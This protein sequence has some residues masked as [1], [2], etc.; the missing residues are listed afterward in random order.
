MASS[1]PPAIARLIKPN[2]LAQNHSRSLYETLSRMPK[3]GVG[4]RVTQPRWAAKG[5]PNCYW[6]ITKVRIKDEGRHGKA[7]GRLFWKGQE[8]KT[9]RGRGSAGERR[10][11]GG[12]KY[13]W[14]HVLLDEFEASQ[15]V[16]ST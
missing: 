11:P 16:S 13:G 6:E 1:L 3:D 8:V 2:P 12:L 5:I 9:V 7:W 4:A 14:K 10:I 15:T